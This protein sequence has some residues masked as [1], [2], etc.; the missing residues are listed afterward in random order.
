MEVSRTL[1][2]PPFTA[3]FLKA[4]KHDL[5]C[6]LS[7]LSFAFPITSPHSVDIEGYGDILVLPTHFRNTMSCHLVAKRSAALHAEVGVIRMLGTAL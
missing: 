1:R 2:L 7:N 4:R 6:T 5:V 3:E